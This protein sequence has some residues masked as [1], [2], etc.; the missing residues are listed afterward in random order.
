M[1]TE[2]PPSKPPK[3]PIL[4]ISS[5]GLDQLSEEERKLFLLLVPAHKRSAIS[6]SQFEGLYDKDMIAQDTAYVEKMEDRFRREEK[7]E[8]AYFKRRA[9]L[10]EAIAR[11]EIKHDNWL[12]PEAKPITA[13][14]YDDIK[15]G[16][17]MIVELFKKDNPAEV[18][19]LL[20]LSVDVTS[21]VTS[22]EDKLAKIKDNILNGQMA[23]VKYFMSSTGARQEMPRVSKVVIGTEAGSIRELSLLRLEI[24]ELGRAIRANKDKGELSPESV[25]SLESRFREAR[26]KLAKHRVQI[27]FL[28]EIE[29]QLKTF[30]DFA[31]K[32]NQPQLILEY[33]KALDKIREIRQEKSTPADKKSFN[34]SPDETDNNDNDGVYRALKTGLK[35]FE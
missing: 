23:Y 29:L 4:E 13:S 25:L 32:N 10:L 26:L 34:L 17:D 19:S 30:L 18:A 24:H 27:L 3:P 8:T 31:D 11:N 16:V 22:L 1:A 5:E 6:L 33:Q 21:N 14:R 20:G 15:N 2:K 28:N 35:I 7:P 12:G 9:E